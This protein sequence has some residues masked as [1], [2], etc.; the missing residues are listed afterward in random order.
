MPQPRVILWKSETR[1]AKSIIDS[2]H[3]EYSLSDKTYFS[4]FD[5]E[6]GHTYKEYNGAC[7]NENGMTSDIGSATLES[8]SACQ[9]KCDKT[10]GCGAV[11]WD[12]K[13]CLMTSSMVT[14]TGHMPAH[15]H[16]KCYSKEK[17]KY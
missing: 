11:T 7:K 14:S 13:E 6:E 12:E 2:L 9:E 3:P 1:L 8:L 15:K 17:G 10:K 16:F 5:Y 4:E